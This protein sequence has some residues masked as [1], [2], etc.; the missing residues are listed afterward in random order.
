MQ[1]TII[2]IQAQ[3]SKEDTFKTGTHLPVL[4][5]ALLLV[6]NLPTFSCIKNHAVLRLGFRA[7]VVINMVIFTGASAIRGRNFFEKVNLNLGTMLVF[8]HYA[9]HEMWSKWRV[10][11]YTTF[12]RGLI[13]PLYNSDFM[14]RSF[15]T[16]RFTTS[17]RY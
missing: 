6:S 17:L 14:Q 1:T 12:K 11:I 4:P 15:L 10:D 5:M 3:N 16:K 13:C 2:N 9:D 7:Q 8:R